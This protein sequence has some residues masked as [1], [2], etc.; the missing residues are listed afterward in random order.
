M[1][2]PGGWIRQS[3]N[4]LLFTAYNY[5]ISESQMMSTS[6]TLSILAWT[7]STSTRQLL[8]AR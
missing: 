8:S 1:W 3:H 6:I 5:S 2:Q 4:D 7:P